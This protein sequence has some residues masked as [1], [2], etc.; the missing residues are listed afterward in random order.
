MACVA[1]VHEDTPE[2]M[3]IRRG[4][5]QVWSPD[6][7]MIAF[8]SDRSDPN[9]NYDVGINDVF[10]AHPDGSDIVN[11]TRSHGF[12]GDPGWSPDAPDDY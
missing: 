8:E 5:A 7:R 9:P 4:Q 11:L 3:F 10:T 2:G 1:T 12:S 6:G